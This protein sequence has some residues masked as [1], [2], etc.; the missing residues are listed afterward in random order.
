MSPEFTFHLNTTRFD[1]NYQPAPT[2]RL[3]TNF[4]NL[5]R[6]QNR[7][8]NLSRTLLMISNRFNQLASWDNPSADRYTVELDIIS[9]DIQL[10]GK[11]PSEVF[12]LIEILQPSILDKTTQQRLEGLPGNSFSS[13][14]RDY[15]FSIRLPAYNLQRTAFGLPEDFGELHGKLFKALTKSAAFTARFRQAPVMCISASTTKTYQRTG[16]RHPILGVEY[17]QNQLSLTD[18]YFQKMGLEV[19][20]FMPENSLGPLA[21]YFQGDLLADYSNL[22]LIGTISTMDTFQKIYRPEIYNA[23]SPAGHLYQPSLHSQDYSLTQVVYDREE[24]R[25][26]ALQQAKYTEEHFLTPYAELLE[27]WAANFPD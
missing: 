7:Q 9:A 17:Q 16:N 15:D 10:P 11:S 8:A 20:F 22:E 2:T 12:P 25:Q 27:H 4:A 24:R 5:A 26:L 6:G 14:L 19:R 3:T 1:E 23:N 21:F 13:Y 18:S